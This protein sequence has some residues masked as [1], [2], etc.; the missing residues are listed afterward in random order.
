[1]TID[2]FRKNPY[3]P[4][5][6][7]KELQ[8]NGILQLVLEVLEESHPARFA[9]PTDI[10]DDISPTKA[11]LML[12]QTKGY[13]SVLTTIRLL[14]VAVRPTVDIGEPTYEKPPREE[15]HSHA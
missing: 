12:G 13:S 5:Q 2:E 11:T 8:T 1:M 15:Q 4:S 6:W 3:L 14:A 9:A 7:R 10:N